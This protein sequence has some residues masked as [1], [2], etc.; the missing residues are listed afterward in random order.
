MRTLRKTLLWLMAIVVVVAGATGWVGYHYWSN[1]DRILHET[2]ARQLNEWYPELKF[3][4]GRF[5]LDWSGQIHVEQFSL[6][7][8]DSE[9]PLI[10][11]PDTIVDLDRDALINR[12]EPV[13]LRLRLLRPQIEATRL[14]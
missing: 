10:D 11:L 8:P 13:I 7:L 4:L 9:R 14:P 12:Q 1:A 2:V 6:T 5:R 3:Q